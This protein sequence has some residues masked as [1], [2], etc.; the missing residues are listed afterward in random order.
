MKYRLLTILLAFFGLLA[1]STASADE[2]T[3]QA[4]GPRQVAL[5]EAFQIAYTVNQTA[6]EPRLASMQ[7]FEVLS[8]PFTSTSQSTSW[9]NGKVTS[10]KEITFTYTL[11]AKK[12]GTFTIGAAQIT[13]DGKKYNSNA[14]KIQVLPEGQGGQQQAQQGRRQGGYQSG[15]QQQAA[16]QAGSPDRLFVKANFSKTRVMEQEAILVTYKLY[17]KD[18][19]VGISSVKKPDFDGFL[20]QEIDIPQIDLKRDSYNGQQYLS[21]ELYKAVLFPQHSGTIPVDKFSCTLAIRVRMQRQARSFFDSFF[22]S[23][24]DVEK[25]IST[26]KTNITVDALPK[27]KPAD[28]SGVVGTLALDTKVSATETESNKPITVTL[29]VSGTGN[30]KMFKTPELKFPQDFETYEPKVTNSFNTTS[31]GQ[32]GKKTIEYL[33]IPRHKGEFVVPNASI[34]YFDL[35]SRQY[36]TLNT[37]EIKFN[38]LKG[39]GDDD[40]T[41]VVQNVKDQEKVAMLAKDI[42]YLSNEKPNI[43]PEEDYLVGTLLYWL[44]FLIIVVLTVALLF[45]FRKQARDNAN[46]ELVKNR[47]ANKVARRRLKVADREWR[48]GNK[49][50]FYD[51][52]LKAMWGYTSDKLSMPLVD[53]NKENIG[54]CLLERGVDNATVDEFLNLLNECEFQRYAPIADERVAMDKTFARTIELISKLEDSIKK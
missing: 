41:T 10:S 36:K 50:R 47:K 42:R 21:C 6:R 20:V 35:S 44:C 49:E 30:I 28:F 38:I 9:I 53:L 32:Q 54:R 29:T 18:D 17:A 27:P 8:G 23:Y 33:V 48:A 4:S 24:Q 40:Q 5:G 2:V 15:G 26:N 52:I 25:T 13:V 34:S 12:E 16:A 31:A 37:G 11:Q 46:M 22:D 43:K 45:F 19:I 1:A 3:F 7:D 39:T 14:L 51:E